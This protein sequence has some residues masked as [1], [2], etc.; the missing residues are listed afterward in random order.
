DYVNLFITQDTVYKIVVESGKN[1]IGG[2]ETS[3][4]NRKLT[5]RNT[6]GCNWVR[7][8]D[9]PINVYISLSNLDKIYYNS[10]GNV[11]SL[12]AIKTDSL[13]VEAWGGCG[14]IELDLDIYSGS[15]YLQI[16]TSDIH[17]SGNCGVVSMFT[18]DFGLLDAR[19]LNCGYAF[20]SNKSSNDCYIQVHEE[21]DA[22]IESI[23]N[24]YYTGSP[25]KIETTINGPGS[26]IAF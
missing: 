13:K 17:L 2:I 5:I 1:I 14:R 12:N 3:I 7:S 16:G 18:G 26:V 11:T 23:G 19:N 4:E 21:L 22:T 15:F 6:N 8:Y 10:S 9:K 25:K 24:I 20:V